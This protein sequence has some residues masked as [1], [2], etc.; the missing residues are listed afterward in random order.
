MLWEGQEGTRMRT[1]MPV[2]DAG[3]W[4]LGLQS[5]V[6]QFVNA[7][8]SHAF[9]N[10]LIRVHVCLPGGRYFF[11]ILVIIILIII[12]FIIIIIMITI[13]I[14]NFSNFFLY[15]GLSTLLSL[16][17]FLR[18][19]SIAV[20]QL[21]YHLYITLNYGLNHYYCHCVYYLDNYYNRY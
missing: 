19:C 5:H 21:N 13:F 12:I 9:S 11:I 7:I 16:L 4:M 2:S 8:A 3:C 6:R 15:L 14:I 10:L 1:R 17:L 18:D 20:F